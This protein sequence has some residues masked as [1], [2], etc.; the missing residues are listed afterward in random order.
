MASL[1]LLVVDDHKVVREGLSA[2]L[3]LE[4][5]LRVVGE[6]GDA[7]E[8]VRLATILQPD[9]VIMDV[10]LESDSGI[11][12][13][14]EIKTLLPEARVLMLTSYSDD[15]AVFSSIVAGAS[16]YLLKNTSK[17]E[18]INAV[19][20][21]GRGEA[22]LDPAITKKV[23]DRLAQL[24]QRQGR[25]AENDLS[26]REREVLA[27]VARGLTNKEIGDRLF[28]SDHTVRNHVSR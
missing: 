15:E 6:A 20:A 2:L 4:D 12:A 3:N 24:S 18:L 26:E 5:D 10:R 25:F 27:L 28:L 16:G 13:C 23:T 14:R 1:K 19:R 7:G 9:V 17:A 11:E 8:A 22:L 21:L